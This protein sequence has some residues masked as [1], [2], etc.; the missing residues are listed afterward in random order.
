MPPR[1]RSALVALALGV[2]A[3]CS[4]AVAR[5]SAPQAGAGD[6]TKMANPALSAAPSAATA[7]FQ[8]VAVAPLETLLLPAAFVSAP[9][10]LT[11][12]Q[13]ARVRALP[14]VS[15]VSV[16]D[17]GLVETGHLSLPLLGVDP[18]TFRALT[19]GATA[20]SDPL[21][22]AVGRGE[23]LIS[24]DAANRGRRSM[25]LGASQGFVGR[26]DAQRPRQRLRLGGFAATGL[27]HAHVIVASALARELGARPQRA[28]IVAATLQADGPELRRQVY[29]VIGAGTH[30]EL[31]GRFA[32]D[33]SQGLSRPGRPRTYRELYIAAARTCPGLS[34]TVLA[35][36]GQIESDHG[37]NAVESSAGALGPM[38]FLPDTFA[39]YGVDG[40]GDGRIDI[41]DPYDAVFS[42][43]R[44]LCHDGANQGQERLKDAIFA[45]NHADWYVTEVL[46]LAERYA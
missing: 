15:G 9:R 8:A 31:I 28:L 4:V 25:T 37:R 21:W 1:V 27:P 14:F 34:W 43:A 2:G 30:V 17:T 44:M 3:A 46:A 26:T 5:T 32:L 11:D 38:Q 40:G 42:A 29:A 18:G 13:I 20:T 36:I 12:E 10:R 45:Y 7:T 35:A 6:V 24:Y 41:N 39:E 16:A 33:E 22:Q 19:P 23:A